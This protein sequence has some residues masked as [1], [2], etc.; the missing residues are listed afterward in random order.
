MSVVEFV[1]SSVHNLLMEVAEILKRKNFYMGPEL[2]FEGNQDHRITNI[3][4]NYMD[5]LA[6][7]GAELGEKIFTEI[8]KRNWSCILILSLKTLLSM[9]LSRQ[10]IFKLKMR[11]IFILRTKFYEFFFLNFFFLGVGVDRKSVV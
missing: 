11:I 3:I 9:I 7:V 6:I 1:K 10:S 4:S 8:R 5:I 2:Y